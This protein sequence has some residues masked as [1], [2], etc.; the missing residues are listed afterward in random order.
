M[1]KTTYQASEDFIAVHY[2]MKKRYK[3]LYPQTI[4]PYIKILRQLMDAKDL[5]AE[6]ALKQI[7]DSFLV[8]PK[9]GE[10]QEKQ[11]LEN[12]KAYLKQRLFVSATMCI[13]EADTDNTPHI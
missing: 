2:E 13:L 12:A 6:Q 1:E 3:E 4:T 5:R 7:N 9:Y 8:K 10:D 11:Q